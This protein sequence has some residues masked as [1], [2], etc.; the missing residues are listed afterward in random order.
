MKRVNFS[1]NFSTI[2]N[3]ASSLNISNQQFASR[4]DSKDTDNMKIFW[5]SH[6]L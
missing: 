1:V 5:V 4:Q 6:K 3:K 2:L